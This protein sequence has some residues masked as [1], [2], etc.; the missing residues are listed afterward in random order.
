LLSASWVSVL[1]LTGGL[2]GCG[3]NARPQS[4][5]GGQDTGADM[6]PDALPDG[7]VDRSNGDGAIACY[8]VTF[9]SPTDGAMLTAADDKSGNQCPNGSFHYDVKIATSAPDQTA[10]VLMNGTNVVGSATAMNGHATFSNVQ[11]D[12][13]GSVQLSIQFPGTQPC[14]GASTRANITIDCHVPTCTISEPDHPVLNGVPAGQG[15][16]RVSAGG[17]PYQ[18]AFAVTTNVENAQMVRLQVA[19]MSSPSNVTTFS[20]N[21]SG[22]AAMFASVTLVPDGTYLVQAACT[23]KNGVVGRSAQVTFVVDTTPPQLT[24]SKPNDGQFFSMG[25]V[26]VCG[27]TTSP[28]AYGLPPSVGALANNF[29]VSAGGGTTCAPET[30]ASTDACV[31]LSCNGGAPFDV[32][33]NLNDGAGNVSSRVVRG[34]SC[35]SSLPSVQIVTPVSDGPGFVDPTK[36]LLAAGTQPFSDTNPVAPGAQTD[37]VACTNR[38]GPAQLYV[39]PKGGTLAALGGAVATTAAGPGQCPSGLGFVATFSSVT[40][41]ESAENMDGSLSVPTELRVD[42]TDPLAAA[43]VGSS[44]LVDIWVDSHAPIISINS[45]GTLCGFHQATTFTTDVALSSDT[46]S[47]VLTVSHGSSTDT[48][49]NPTWDGT[50]ASFAAVPFPEGANDIGATASDLAGN[51]STLPPPTCTVTVGAAPVV[52]F[53]APTTSSSGKILC[54]ATSPNPSCLADGNSGLAGWQGP[55]AVTVTGDG[56]PLAGVNVTFS[57]GA[58]MLGIRVTDSAGNAQLGAS[59]TIPD[60]EP[61]TITATTD[62]VPN[63]GVGTGTLTVNVVTLPPNKPTGLKDPPDVAVRRETSF[64]LSWTAP[65][66]ENGKRV[67]SYDVRV[68]RVAIDANNFDNPAVTTVVPYSA[69]PAAPGSPDGA[70]AHNLYIENSYFFAVAAVD[71]AGN[72]GPIASTAASAIAHFNRTL[73]PSTSGSNEELGYSLSGEGDLNGDGLSDILAGTFNGGKAYLYFGSMALPPN[74]NG[75]APNVVFSGPSPGF[76]AAVAQIGDVDG[77]G[78]PDVAISDT[79]D[80]PAIYIFKGRMTWPPM[81]DAATQ[82]DYLITGG[83]AYTGSLFGFSLARL[84][85][86]TGDR[87]DDFAVGA[88]AFG[89]AIGQVVIIPG[90]AGGLPASITLPDATN[91]IVIGGD[92]ALGKPLFGYRVLGLGH[93]YSVTTGTTLI[94]S[95]PGRNS[96][97]LASPGHVYAFHGQTGTGGVISLPADQTIAGPAAGARIGFVLSN[98][99]P[100]LGALPAVGVGNPANGVD[101][102]TVGDAYVTTGTTGLGPMGNRVIVYMTGSVGEIGGVLLGG[103][104]P[105]RDG[106][107]S[108]I[109]DSG[110]DLLIGAE[111][112]S[113]VAIFDGAKLGAKTSPINAVVAAEVQITLP[114]SWSTGEAA[115]SLVP[116]VDGDGFLDFCLGNA[117]G[118]IPGAVAVYW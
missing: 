109:G 71:I 76:G 48:F 31:T 16:D 25:Q 23:A 87:V 115:A 73:F 110:A 88:P 95:G 98:L 30:A 68:A 6:R 42:V 47:V 24:V 86:F 61:V 32:T 34:I 15:G 107:R 75:A 35:V 18:A 82:K 60:G 100:L 7:G 3:D 104:L 53:T 84:G 28:D 2:L 106:A 43:A 74:G 29:C 38:N 5:G 27:S 12:S 96:S 94:A 81:L 41:A 46:A 54:G 64:Q 93:F 113:T 70:I 22:G 17:Q 36:H 72:R 39:G 112:A 10:I 90:K 118:P 51:G 21:A 56:A 105:G 83:A 26:Q 67:A 78:L 4:D 50:T 9:L 97:P 62:P 99:G 20:S 92:A 1:A 37:V 85:D 33:V 40:L 69:T 91:T 111:Q 101:T 108:L 8:Q 45:P 66:D 65:S 117:F 55:V 13:Q 49:R 11:L 57:I 103:G 114:S 58:T 63:R 77:D 59:V 14:T 116:D 102:G 89:S 44:P 79:D 80:P 52:V 19:N